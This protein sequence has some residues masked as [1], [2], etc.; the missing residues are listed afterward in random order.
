MW[1]LKIRTF[2]DITNA[3]NNLLMAHKNYHTLKYSGKCENKLNL[4]ALKY[5]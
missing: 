4:S 5:I 2:N 1:N 3:I